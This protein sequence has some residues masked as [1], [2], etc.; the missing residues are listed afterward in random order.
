MDVAGALGTTFGL[1]WIPLI[2]V[3]IVGVVVWIAG[4][5]ESN[6]QWVRLGQRILLGT[7]V[8]IIFLVIGH[9]IAVW[10]GFAQG[11]PQ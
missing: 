2:I 8:G 9:I 5:D 3:V 11:A 1:L 10:L 4:D 7:A 6:E